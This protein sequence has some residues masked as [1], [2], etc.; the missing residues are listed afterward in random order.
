MRVVE[1]GMAEIDCTW[2]YTGINLME[3]QYKRNRRWWWWRD[4]VM[5]VGEIDSVWGLIEVNLMEFQS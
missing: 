2:E 4:D 5:V 1:I 3:F